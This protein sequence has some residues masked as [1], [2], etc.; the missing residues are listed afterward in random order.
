MN[1]VSFSVAGPN[2]IEQMSDYMTD[3]SDTDLVSAALEGM[4]DNVTQ[5]DG[6]VMDLPYN[7]EGC[8]YRGRRDRVGALNIAQ[9]T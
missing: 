4:L 1:R 7:L 3:L 6:T 5:D 8:G 2:E 9:T